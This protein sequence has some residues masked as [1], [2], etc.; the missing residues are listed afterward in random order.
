MFINRVIKPN[1]WVSALNANIDKIVI[2]YNSGLKSFTI[3]S[4]SKG[5]LAYAPYMVFEMS[6]LK[7][8]RNDLLRSVSNSAGL[9]NQR[10]IIATNPIENV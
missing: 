5:T 10:F 7:V 1:G 6:E 8:K 4:P 9:G 3:V 2:L